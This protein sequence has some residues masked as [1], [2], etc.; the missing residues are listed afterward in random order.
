MRLDAGLVLGREQDDL[1]G[2]DA[3]V[4]H[5]LRAAIVLLRSWREDLDEHGRIHVRLARRIVRIEFALAAVD[6]DIRVRAQAGRLDPEF[7]ITT[8][9][10]VRRAFKL[11][12]EMAEDS[13]ADPA[14]AGAAAGHREYLPVI[15]LAAVVGLCLKAV[16]FVGR[17]SPDLLGIGHNRVLVANGNVEYQFE[18][19][20]GSDFPI[21]V[22]LMV[23]VPW[24]IRCIKGPIRPWPHGSTLSSTAHCRDPRASA[25][26]AGA[27]P[28]RARERRSKRRQRRSVP[29]GCR[30]GLGVGISVPNP[31]IRQCLLKF[32]HAFVR[33]FGVAKEQPLEMAQSLEMLQTSVG[34]LGAVKPQLL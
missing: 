1:E 34:D 23:I 6:G 18:P 15:K 28:P 5:G 22:L 24:E 17:I 19:R 8:E 4:V 31:A 7:Q 13:R 12:S 11:V 25:R 14:V 27:L 2:L 20:P 30:H 21:S 29:S 3:T 10:D 26:Q 16:I 32:L 33:D 9:G